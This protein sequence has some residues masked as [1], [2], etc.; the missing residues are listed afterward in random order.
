MTRPAARLRSKEK[1]ED[2]V[3]EEV[4]RLQP[5]ATGD[6]AVYRVTKRMLTTPELQERVAQKLNVPPRSVVFPALKDRRAV[7]T[8]HFSIR[9]RGPFEL[10]GEGFTARFVGRAPRHLAPGDLAGNRFRIRLH[11]VEAPLAEAIARRLVELEREGLPNYFDEQRFGSYVPGQQHIGK[12][13]LQ[14]DAEGALRAYLAQPAPG[15]PPE[16]RRF[17][18]LAQ[19]H[20]GDWHGLFQRAPR[21]NQRSILNFL[22]DH[23]GDLRKA[24][25]LITPRLLPL[26]LESYQGLLWNRTASRFL[27]RRL[28]ISGVATAFVEVAGERLAVYR[29][30]P[31]ALLAKL[32]RISLPLPHHRA[33]YP[34]PELEAL[35]A[36]VL[37]QEGLTPHDLKPR[38]LERAYLPRGARPLL[39]MPRQV[40]A[41]TR[42]TPAEDRRFVELSFFLPPG[43][44]ATLVV[45]VLE[46]TAGLA[47]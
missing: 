6:Y 7:A 46:A 1:A 30:L 22:K 44:Y 34:T 47:T 41:V 21:S 19:E 8:Q 2:F 28:A 45:K 13:I 23:P 27:Q 18:A 26:L 35:A 14:G 42:V 11:A 33:T 31:V 39:V 40:E 38:M 15:D 36:E 20:W 43:S 16:M 5:G 3:V 32:E 4:L 17:K 9:G 10:S 29:A 12:A 25:D 37:A 24:V